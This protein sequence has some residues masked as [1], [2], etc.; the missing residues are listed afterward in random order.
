ML[1]TLSAK[2]NQGGLVK[3]F[4]FHFYVGIV[5]VGINNERNN[6]SGVLL[7]IVI[8]YFIVFTSRL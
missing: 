5:S 2:P 7:N 3:E 1:K 4:H 8:N 6:Y